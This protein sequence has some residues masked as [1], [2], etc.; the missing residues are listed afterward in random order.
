[1]IDGKQRI[2]TLLVYV[3]RLRGRRF[4]APL[5]L[6]QW[7]S[8]KLVSWAQL[9][10]LKQ[11]HRFEEYQL[12]VVEVERSLRILLSSLFGSIHRGMRSAGRK[13]VA[14]NST[15]TVS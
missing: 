2:E 14:P 9:R 1:V 6:P 3:G 7:E 12:Q 15:E 10:K 13:F 4:A 5:H 11:Q 8:P